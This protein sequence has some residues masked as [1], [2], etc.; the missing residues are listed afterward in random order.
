MEVFFPA[1]EHQAILA[2]K[3]RLL[4]EYGLEGIDPLDT[5]LALCANEAESTVP[6]ASSSWQSSPENTGTFRPNWSA[7]GTKNDF[8]KSRRKSRTQRL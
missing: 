1:T 4:Q 5:E 3:K 6:V 8:R 2:E 7:T